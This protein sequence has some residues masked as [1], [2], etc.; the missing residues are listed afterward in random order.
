MNTFF[1]I[2]GIIFSVI[3]VLVALYY[4]IPMVCNLFK[5]HI[6][7]TMTNLWVGLFGV[8]KSMKG[9]CLKAWNNW[10][11]NH[12]G[13]RHHFHSNRHLKKFAYIQFLKQVRKE[14][15]ENINK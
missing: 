13:T 14:I 5:E 7:P 9:N 3:L 12:P 10:Y 11:T 1:T 8:R 15:H 6:N 4:I 2:M